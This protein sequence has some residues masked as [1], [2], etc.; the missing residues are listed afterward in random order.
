ML[1]FAN[2]PINNLLHLC[3]ETLACQTQSGRLRL[4]FF[5]VQSSRLGR[6]DDVFL[7][8]FLPLVSIFTSWMM[9]STHRIR[10]KGARNDEVCVF[11]WVGIGTN[12]TLGAYNANFIAVA[13]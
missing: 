3:M 2:V 13:S 6:D 4:L 5:A 10:A 11:W 12:Q 9:V 8:L 1:S 7:F